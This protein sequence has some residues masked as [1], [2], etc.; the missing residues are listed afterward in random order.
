MRFQYSRYRASFIGSTS[1]PTI[2]VLDSFTGGGAS[3][4]PSSSHLHRFELRDEL[5]ISNREHVLRFGA[6]VR[7]VLLKDASSQTFNGNFLFAGGSAP[8]LGAG[9]QLILDSSGNSS[10]IPVTS[11]ERYRRTLVFSQRGLSDSAIRARGG[12]AS[13]FLLAGGHPAVSLNQTDAGFFVEDNWRVRSN[14]TLGMGLR[15]EVQNHLSDWRDF[16]PRVSLAWAPGTSSQKKPKTVIRLGS[17]LF[18]DRFS[19]NLTLQ[20]VRFNGSRQQQVII[21][22]RNF[23]PQV[24]ALA[25]LGPFHPIQTI[26]QSDA[27]LRSPEII[28]NAA[29]L[30]FQLPGKNILS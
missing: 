29:G 1:V 9:D 13:Q 2:S 17:G 26:H 5:S 10:F 15:Y 18:Y 4:G 7:T 11:L 30:E 16:A 12:G 24:P 14:L 8:L 25:D 21:K 22:D 23:F 28:Q 3:V 19:E 20:T 27:H 6:R